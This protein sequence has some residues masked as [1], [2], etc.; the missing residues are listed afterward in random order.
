MPLLDSQV[1]VTNKMFD[2]NLFGLVAVNQAFAPLLIASSGIIVNI[3]S[4]VGKSPLPWQGLLQC[5][6]S[7]SKPSQ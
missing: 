5:K 2:V 6:Q 4:I 1:A 3:G 7:S